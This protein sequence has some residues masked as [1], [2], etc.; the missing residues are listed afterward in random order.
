MR[1]ED[2]G[3]IAVLLCFR[4]NEPHE[5]LKRAI[6]STAACA[7]A[8]TTFFLHADGGAPADRVDLES[9]AAKCR[10]DWTISPAA[11]GLAAGLN[12]LIDRVLERPEFGLLAR[13]DADDVS[14]EGRL[15][16]QRDYFQED[17]GLDILGTACRERDEDGNFLQTKSI[18]AT[19][20]EILGRLPW[21]NPMNHPTVMLRRRVFESGLRYRTNVRLMEDYFLWVDAAAAG[22]RFANLTEPWLEYTRDPGFFGR[23]SGWGQAC[24]EWNVRR[25]AARR[26]GISS[27]S[28]WMAAGSAFGLRLLP[29][30]AQACL[31]KKLR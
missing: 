6:A 23:R 25:H 7:P 3:L 31:Y 22:F 13:M 28:A 26:L 4:Q 5:R 10:M 19:H 29:G 20:E 15:A 24:A 21:R 30:A 14:V 11:V 18:P 8:G 16:R 17:P 27:L 1:P 9:A 2:P 12:R